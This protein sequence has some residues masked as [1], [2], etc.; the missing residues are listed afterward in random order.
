MKEGTALAQPTLPHHQPA[1]PYFNPATSAH[2]SPYLP[3]PMLPSCTLPYL[4]LFH[5][6]PHSD[7]HKND[8]RSSNLLYPHPIP[9]SQKE[10]ANLLTPRARPSRIDTESP[11]EGSGAWLPENILGW[12]GSLSYPPQRG[13]RGSVGGV[14][15]RSAYNSTICAADVC[16][17]NWLARSQ[18][19]RNT[20]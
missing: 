5:P 20:N 7:I 4:T 18:F 16:K 10:R 11:L 12:S 6:L 9:R 1:L 2:L 15:G 19:V 13:E 17:I 3:Y 8:L 14:K